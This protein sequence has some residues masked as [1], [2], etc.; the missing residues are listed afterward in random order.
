MKQFTH[1]AYLRA[2]DFLKT[3]A[4]P[5]ERAL[6][7]YQFEGGTREAV[8][9]ALAG[10]QNP[11]GGFGHA[12]EPDLRAP[13]SSALATGHALTWLWKTGIPA[14]HEMV[15][16]AVRW[17][18]ETLDPQTRVWRIVPPGANE[19][20]HAPWWHEDG[21]SLAQ[22][23]E[24]FVIAPRGEILAGLYHFGAQRAWLDALAEE[25]VAAVESLPP[26]G[27]NIGYTSQLAEAQ[28]LPEPLRERLVAYLRARAPEVVEYDPR[29]W[30]EYCL[31][32]VWAAQTPHS[33]LADLLMEPIQQNLDYIIDTQKP[34]GFWE[35]NWSWFGS[36]PEVWEQQARPEW[37]GELTLRNLNFLRVFGRID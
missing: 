10:Y 9:A 32:P 20:P 12:L 15:R 14:E 4:R 23:F 17:S 28:G 7:E 11:D 26:G 25:T 35:P 21:H 6:F 8:I 27:E 3:Q 5:I 30:A 24:D 16:R 33:P 2:R 37:Q 13:D 29:K 34:E 31:A 19:Y 18:L 36:Y 1:E 22:T